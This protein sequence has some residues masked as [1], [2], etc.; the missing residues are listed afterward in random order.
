MGSWF[1]DAVPGQASR[2][3]A[4]VGGPI[5]PRE[6]GELA[7]IAGLFRPRASLRF[8]SQISRVSDRNV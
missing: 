3:A 5:A 4:A 6:A 2:A 1:A 7:K 8:A